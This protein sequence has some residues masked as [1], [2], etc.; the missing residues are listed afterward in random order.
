MKWNP[1][2]FPLYM[3]KIAF[4]PIFTSVS[5]PQTQH[6]PSQYTPK[7]HA[8]GL[9]CSPYL[10]S[11]QPLPLRSSKRKKDCKGSLG[12]GVF[13]WRYSS[14]LSLY[15]SVSFSVILFFFEWKV[16]CVLAL[17]VHVYFKYVWADML[18]NAF[19]NI[20]G[21]IITPKPYHLSMFWGRRNWP[22]KS[23]IEWYICLT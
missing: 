20:M 10:E 14:V 4:S 18:R 5:T 2:S 23:Y 3:Y 17:L 16:H 6:T 7:Y 9:H 8:L 13:A 21:F 19:D 15:C 22:F 11:T 12:D 1:S